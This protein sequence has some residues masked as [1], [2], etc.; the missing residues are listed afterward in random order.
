MSENFTFGIVGGYGATGRMV[1]AEL[2]KA[3]EW[4]IL[5][6]GRDLA[7]ARALAAKFDG[8]VTAAQV[9]VLDPQSLD[10]FCSRCSVV[11]N[12]AGPV[13]QLQDRVAQATLRRRCHYVDPAGLLFVKER[14][15]PHNREI[16][17]LG[18]SF[19]VSAGWLP[20][21]SEIVPLYANAQA[22][23]KMKTIDSLT[24]YFGDAGEWSDNAF[25]DAVGYIRESGI[26]NPWY[27]RKGERVTVRKAAPFFKVGLGGRLGSQRFSMYPLPEQN[28]IGQRLKGCDFTAY[29]YLPSLRTVTAGA[30]IA[31]F[32]LP[33]TWAIRLLRNAF[34]RN[35]LAVGGFVVAEVHGQSQG[36]PVV[37]KAQV[38]FEKGQDYWIN[39]LV[40]ATVARMVA[41]ANGVQVGVNFLGDAVDPAALM[42]E[43]G[44]P[45]S[46]WQGVSKFVAKESYNP[47][48][49]RIPFTCPCH[50]SNEL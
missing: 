36:H 20:G 39:G 31:I 44:K 49:S 34:R 48:F 14:M 2:H 28:E 41:A 21:L 6:G 10:E 38:M 37:L 17:D 9:D 24:V 13:M 40:L 29:T 35:R 3:T 16:A 7:Q 5:I 46:R 22:R 15:L 25:R 32:P 8:R 23:T 47:V 45:E 19:V 30:L 27:F 12:C 42:A 33:E 26:H 18:L 50:A 4:Q 1:A 43:L 11:I